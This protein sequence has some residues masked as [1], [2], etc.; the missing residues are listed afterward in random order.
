MRCRVSAGAEGAF[1]GTGMSISVSVIV[2][3][4]ERARPEESVLWFAT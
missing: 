1:F 3:M 4:A 2:T